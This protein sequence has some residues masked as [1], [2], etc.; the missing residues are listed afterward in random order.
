VSP[1]KW[2]SPPSPQAE[3][4]TPDSSK[5][6]SLKGTQ[7]PPGVGGAPTSPTRAALDL[8]T[9]G[10]SLV[11]GPTESPRVSPPSPRSHGLRATGGSH[12][13][14]GSSA[15]QLEEVP[16]QRSRVTE[17]LWDNLDF[18]Q[19]GFHVGRFVTAAVGTKADRDNIK[20]LYSSLKTTSDQID[21]SALTILLIASPCDGFDSFLTQAL[22]KHS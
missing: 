12:S 9:A 5:P 7:G 1:K 17:S 19:V 3:R 21:V 15:P 13:G 8:N 16:R 6:S 2:T 18:I 10:T 11:P 20:V 4:T 22:V 14:E